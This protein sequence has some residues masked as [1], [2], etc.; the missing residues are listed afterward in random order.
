MAGEDT[1][2]HRERERERKEVLLLFSGCALWQAQ[3]TRVMTVRRFVV[4]DT[5]SCRSKAMARCISRLG[6]AL[7]LLPRTDTQ[8]LSATIAAALNTGRPSSSVRHLS[9][10]NVQDGEQQDLRQQQVSFNCR[11]EYV[12][13]PLHVLPHFVDVASC[14]CVLRVRAYKYHS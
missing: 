5:L 12:V 8:S 7:N 1:D 9:S 2:G 10:K 4:Q 14:K 11:L 13:K 6:E 3:L